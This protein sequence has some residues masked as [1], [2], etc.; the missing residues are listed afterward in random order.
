MLEQVRLV[1]I[2]F[3]IGFL[4]RHFNPLNWSQI[5]EIIL[6]KLGQISPTLLVTIGLLSTVLALCV[7]LWP[8]ARIADGEAKNSI[9]Y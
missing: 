3:A 5:K 8:L 2:A 9:E 6:L 7:F 1:L 4:T